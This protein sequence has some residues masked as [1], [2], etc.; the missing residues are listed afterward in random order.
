MALTPLGA[1]AAGGRLSAEDER[2]RQT[3]DRERLGEGEAEAV[4]IP[5]LAPTGTFAYWTFPVLGPDPASAVRFI[6]T[7]PWRVLQL[8]V[9]PS[10]KAHTLLS[11]VFPAAF[12][13]VLSPYV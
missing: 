10:V 5:A 7:Q 11:L 3:E 13:A 6:V 8:L 12:L 2:E 1:G 9:T 4:V